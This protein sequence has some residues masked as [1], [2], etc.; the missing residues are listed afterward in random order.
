MNW[1]TETHPSITL[2]RLMVSAPE[3]VYAELQSYGEHAR[4]QSFGSG[5]DELERSLLGRNDPLIDLGLALYAA[6]R[7]IVGGLYSRAL[8]GTGAPAHD[9]GVRLACL[10]NRSLGA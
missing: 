5:D 4:S 8:E 6:N 2:A 7:E 9:K 10:S 1:D 3:V